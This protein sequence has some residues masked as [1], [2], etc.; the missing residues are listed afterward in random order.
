[1]ADFKVKLTRAA[2]V[3][4]SSPPQ[5]QGAQGGATPSGQLEEIVVTAPRVSTRE[6]VVFDATPEFSESRTIN[7]KNI[8][9]I[10]APGGIY[11][12]ANTNARTFSI[13]GKLISRSV[14]E[15]T[16]NLAY[17]Q[18]LRTWAMPVFGQVNEDSPGLASGENI[19]G[20]PPALLF[21]TAYANKQPGNQAVQ[22]TVPVP[23][24]GTVPAIGNNIWQVPV[25][26]TQL[27]IPYPSDVDYI[28]TVNQIPFPT[29][30][31]ISISLVEAHS[32]NAY[33]N[34]TLQDF[35]TGNLLHF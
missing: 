12:Y 1:M 13:Q 22:T 19:L 14:F 11:M 25:I 2:S 34:F 24:G 21:L 31:V 15:A 33:T 5:T 4:N 30:V 7:Y 35:K 20:A 27:D 10:H 32:P 16:K 3:I 6:T 28:P 8:D 9:P 29:I 18:Y 23:G 17:V 26:I